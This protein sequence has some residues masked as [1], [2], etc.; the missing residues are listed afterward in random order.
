MD[1]GAGFTERGKHAVCCNVQLID[2][3]LRNFFIEFSNKEIKE[4]K[5]ERENWEIKG[6]CTMVIS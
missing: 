3:L 5:R 1:S 2:K 6:I 4:R